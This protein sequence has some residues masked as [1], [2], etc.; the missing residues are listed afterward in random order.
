MRNDGVPGV[1]GFEVESLKEDATVRAK[2]L[3]A[4]AA[5]LTSKTYGPSPVLRRLSG[6]RRGQTKRRP[7]GIPTVKNRVVPVRPA[8]GPERSRGTDCGG[9]SAATDHGSRPHERD[10]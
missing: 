2:W 10:E 7:P 6:E 5:E 1:D 3:T 8:P 9:D 4:H